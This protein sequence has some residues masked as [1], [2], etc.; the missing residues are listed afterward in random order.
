[1]V[2]NDNF[3]NFLGELLHDERNRL[4]RRILRDRENPMELLTE[5]EFR[6]RYRLSK[7][8]VRDVLVP[9]VP[10]QNADSRGL[11]LP[12]ILKILTCLRFYATG[13]FQVSR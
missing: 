1:M 4:P 2:L 13:S 9:M 8:T 10:P 6:M 12:P 7:D 11:P 3:A 5:N